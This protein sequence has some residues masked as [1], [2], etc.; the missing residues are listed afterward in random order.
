MLPIPGAKIREADLAS[1]PV[2][3]IGA[4]VTLFTMQI[5]MNPGG[6]PV[7]ELVD[8]FVG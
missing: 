6:F 8:Q 4:Q 5:I 7:A 3:V 1:S 2:P